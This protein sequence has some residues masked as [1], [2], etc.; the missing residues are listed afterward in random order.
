MS[1]GYVGQRHLAKNK[2]ADALGAAVI[3]GD[4]E[5]IEFQGERNAPKK[6]RHQDQAAVENGNNGQLPV[7][8]ILGN[9]RGQFVEA[10][11]DRRFV[12][13]DSLEVFLHRSI[14]YPPST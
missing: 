14:D 4:A 9:P 7:T 12:E 11:M 3:A 6:I 8:V 10:A 1:S 5:A 2:V 13:K